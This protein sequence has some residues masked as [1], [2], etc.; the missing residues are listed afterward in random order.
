MIA[1]D[2]QLWASAATA[3]AVAR[4]GGSHGPTLGTKTARCY[5]RRMATIPAVLAALPILDERGA[6]L[7]LDRLW[8]ERT[9][10]I[11]LVRHFG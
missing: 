5:G 6:E 7:R 4:S 10:L 9:A 3:S 11:A 2:G 1:P 8:H